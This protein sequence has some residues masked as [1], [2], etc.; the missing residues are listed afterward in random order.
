ML[1][2]IVEET[3]RMSYSNQMHGGNNQIVTAGT[4]NALKEYFTERFPIKEL[5]RQNRISQE[6]YDRWH[7]KQ[8]EQISNEVTSEY[9]GNRQ[10]NSDAIS[11]KFLNTFM[12]QLIKYEQ[13]RYLYEKLHLPLD[14]KVLQALSGENIN[15]NEAAVEIPRDLREIARDN[16]DDAY[17]ITYD[18]YLSIQNDLLNLKDEFNQVCPSDFKLNARI[19][20]NAFLWT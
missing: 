7:R 13:F 14:K 1:E 16:K 9:M 5:W 19:E 15:V 20:L 10:N 12:H 2:Q 11:A 4:K 3:A 17:A 18:N 6:R 8:I